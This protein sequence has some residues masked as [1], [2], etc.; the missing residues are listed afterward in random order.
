MALKLRISCKFD[1]TRFELI[2]AAIMV[3]LAVFSAGSLSAQSTSGVLPPSNP[4]PASAPS[5]GAAVGTVTFSIRL[6]VNPHGPAILR[7][8]NRGESKISWFSISA[9]EGHSY[10]GMDAHTIAVYR[11]HQSQSMCVQGISILS[12][13]FYLDVPSVN[14]C[15]GA[16]FIKQSR[17]KWLVNDGGPSRVVE[18]PLLVAFNTGPMKYI[19]PDQQIRL[20]P[21]RHNGVAVWGQK[22]PIHPKR[23]RSPVIEDAGFSRLARHSTIAGTE[24][25][26]QVRVARDVQGSGSISTCA[27]GTDQTCADINVYL[28]SRDRRKAFISAIPRVMIGKEFTVEAEVDP[29]GR[30]TKRDVEGQRKGN[31]VQESEVP[32]T[33]EMAAQ[34]DPGA[35]F[36][37]TDNR[38]GLIEQPVNGQFPTTWSWKLKAVQ[39]GEDVEPIHVRLFAIVL[40]HRKKGPP[41]PIQVLNATVHVDTPPWYDPDQFLALI[42]K[43]SKAVAGTGIVAAVSTIAAWR[44]RR[45]VKRQQ[46][47]ERLKTPKKPTQAGRQASLQK[48]AAT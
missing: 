44:R 9:S 30:V 5:P 25:A 31:V 32:W 20:R 21:N 35:S 4:P 14:L 43:Y 17:Y 28:N 16:T 7:F 12:P 2:G 11:L 6:L 10:N 26:S 48:R 18:T 40:A 23:G 46:A 37:E 19:A 3:L 27:Y 42:T 33:L 39:S 15:S 13:D 34:L 41:I 36:V 24:T 38:S 8:E 29:S 1:P 22:K 47:S 45:T